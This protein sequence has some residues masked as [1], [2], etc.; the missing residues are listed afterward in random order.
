MPFAS[1]QIWSVLADVKGY[2]SWYPRSLN[3]KVLSVTAAGVGS[4][5]E[6]S[7]KGGRPFRCRL[8]AMEPPRR[9][10]FRYP[11]DFI[12]GDGEWRLETAGKGTTVTYEINVAAHGL[13]VLWL[14][15]L[16]PLGKLHS[17]LMR[18]V[19]ENLERE[20]ARR[21]GADRAARA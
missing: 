1:D 9:M 16:L 12:V 21:S 18:E 11:G 8:D 19:L 14:G 20:T 7:P 17:K 5:V 4:E 3:L 13:V 10:R 15:K 2:A 6:L